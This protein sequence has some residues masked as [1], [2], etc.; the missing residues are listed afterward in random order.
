[1]RWSRQL[2]VGTNKGLARVMAL[3]FLTVAISFAVRVC[4]EPAENLLQM[5]TIPPPPTPTPETDETPTPTFTPEPTA[6]STDTAMPTPTATE[7]PTSTPTAGATATA[8]PTPFPCEEIF[9]QALWVLPDAEGSLLGTQVSP[10]AGAQSQVQ[11]WL[12]AH[13]LYVVGVEGTLFDP[14]GGA[15][16]GL[17][18]EAVTGD[19]VIASAVEAA[20]TSGLIDEEQA[21]AIADALAADEGKVFVA[22]FELGSSAPPGD[23]DLEAWLTSEFEC[24]HQPASVPFTHL[25]LVALD[26]DLQYF[27]FGLVEPNKVSYIGGDQSFV[28]D[29]GWPTMRNVGNV[30]VLISLGFS[31]MVNEAG[32]G[33]IVSFRARFLGQELE[34]EAAETT[35]FAHALPP[36]SDAA[37]DFW[38]IPPQPLPVGA[39]SGELRIG[40]QAG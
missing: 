32:I 25:E 24:D 17:A 3:G 11:V 39:Y 5:E 6:T 26:F 15:L 13:S 2:P 27:D 14:D 7:E 1:M 35:V 30:P 22:T 12:V 33:E 36:G 19:A 34:F 23:Y 31:P 8:T 29:D 4:A 38:L 18:F 10:A 20:I 16:F 21:A 28:P 40:A 9:I 37:I